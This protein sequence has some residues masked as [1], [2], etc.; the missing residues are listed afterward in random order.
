MSTERET[1]A[2]GDDAVLRATFAFLDAFP[3]TPPSEWR[4]NHA[5][6]AVASP[7]QQRRYGDQEHDAS[8]TLPIDHEPRAHP[9]VLIDESTLQSLVG[10]AS[11]GAGIAPDTGHAPLLPS[12]PSQPLVGCG[13]DAV[14]AMQVPE[15][16]KKKKPRSWNPNKARNERKDEILYLRKKASELEI[17]LDDIKRRRPE[18]GSFIES[19]HSLQD[20]SAIAERG[21]Q[22]RKTEIHPAILGVWKGIVSRQSVARTQ[23]ERENV[24]LKLVLE[25]QLKLAKSLEEMLKH[26]SSTQ[27]S[28]LPEIACRD[29]FHDRERFYS[30]YSLNTTKHADAEIFDDLISGLDQSYAQVDSVFQGN[31]LASRETELSDARMRFD[32]SSDMCLEIFANKVLPFGMHA[33]ANAAW[34]HFIFGKQRTPSRF[35]DYI[36]SSH[37]GATDDTIVENFNMEL[38]AK[39]TSG[40]FRVKQVFRRYVEETRIV[41]VSRSIFFPVQ[42]AGV[43]MTDVCFRS[44]AYVVVKRPLK[45]TMKMQPELD[46]SLLQ[47][48]YNYTSLVGDDHPKVGVVTDFMLRA[49]EANIRAR[50]QMI[51]NVLLLSNSQSKKQSAVLAATLAFVDAFESPRSDEEHASPVDDDAQ[52]PRR[53]SDATAERTEEELMVELL[54]PLEDEEVWTP[55]DGVEAADAGA[56]RE[57]CSLRDEA[58]LSTSPVS[59][60]QSFVSPS[61]ELHS[62]PHQPQQPARHL[63]PKPALTQKKKKRSLSWNPNRARDERRDELVYLRGKVVELNA[64]LDEMRAKTQRRLDEEASSLLPVPGDQECEYLTE[65][66][67]I[68]HMSSAFTHPGE[69]ILHLQQQPQPEPQQQH[70]TLRGVWREIAIRQNRERERA[71]REN[72]R[73]KLVLEDQLKIAKSWEKLLQ[74]KATTQEMEKLIVGKRRHHKYPPTADRTDAEIFEDLLTG[75]DKAYANMEAV[76]TANGLANL[77]GAYNDARIRSDRSRGIM[78]LEICSSRVLPFDVHST[79]TAAW[80]HFVYGRQKVPARYYDFTFTKN[81]DVTEDTFVESFNLELH[82]KSTAAHLRVKKAMRRFD[83]KLS[84]QLTHIVDGTVQILRRHKQAAQTPMAAADEGQDAAARDGFHAALALAD[85]IL[86]SAPIDGESAELL[87]SLALN[88]DV[89]DA[90]AES[91]RELLLP[92]KDGADSLSGL[93]A[94]SA[95][96]NGTLVW[97]EHA[98]AAETAREPQPSTQSPPAHP[99][100][101]QALQETRGKAATTT[102]STAKKKRV[103]TWNPNRARDERR[104]EML[105]LRKRVDDL[106]KQL[107]EI[108][109]ADERNKKIKTDDGSASTEL[110]CYNLSTEEES[111]LR[112]SSALRQPTEHALATRHKPGEPHPDVK[113]VWRDIATRQKQA[114]MHAERENVRLRLVLED[115]LKI[116]KSW[117]KM[118]HRKQATHVGTSVFYEDCILSLRLK[119]ITLLVCGYFEQV[120]GNFIRDNRRHPEYLQTPERTEA[121]IFEDLLT[122][123]DSSY[124]ELDAAFAANGLDK[125]EDVYS[126]ARIRTDRSTGVIYLEICSSKVLPFDIHSTGTAAWN[127]FVFGRQRVPSRFYDFNLF[128]KTVD[129]TEDTIVESFNLELHAKSTAA[130]LCVRKAMRRFVEEDRIVI[131]FRTIFYPVELA[132]EP[133]SGMCF[134]VTGYI[135]IKRPKTIPGNYS[136]LQMCSK[137]TPTLGT[138]HPKAGV[139]TELLLRTA[140]ANFATSHQLI[141]NVLL[142]QA[143]KKENDKDKVEEEA[144]FH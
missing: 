41:I 119:L 94:A 73:L 124:A 38:H 40:Y 19:S 49:T 121:E 14:S 66:E 61:T 52:Q 3:V 55:D 72:I 32:A 26:K 10:N 1:T 111:M 116:A 35:Y 60:E 44:T 29:V 127:H 79:G 62:Q 139:M 100:Q 118:L 96:E 80:N 5:V 93:S 131:V 36:F 70:P 104:N 89:E 42:V 108:I 98:S 125:I 106:T 84:F 82:A 7:L 129:V 11:G 133:M 25:Q 50:H 123:I 140:E 91:L 46:C 75:I 53:S 63:A 24:R 110:A 67:S 83:E 74:R 78:Y 113:Y 90:D 37:T 45:T 13:V 43:A 130:H 105:Y 92:L 30:L 102:A 69:K 65:E 17:Q 126:D 88:G 34:Q 107:N 57:S 16:K 128:A 23:A 39:N 77:E 18:T 9:H 20:V 28:R 81:V 135:V 6:A 132:E 97:S 47:T 76:F 27:V 68:L 117:E 95:H 15:P 58:V 114:R 33:V 136:L 120:M 143:M 137:Y 59:S 141:E 122:G 51:E 21:M 4:E 12:S 86:A 31:G 101:E 56:S 115:Q 103:R 112:M 134:L 54:L 85:E 8:L 99:K 48:S 144:N 109:N 64:K 87:P 71:E 142:E 2:E 22:H 138:D